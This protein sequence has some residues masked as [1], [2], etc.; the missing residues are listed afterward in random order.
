MAC[1]HPGNFLWGCCHCFSSGAKVSPVASQ[2]LASVVFV[3]CYQNVPQQSCKYRDGQ[4]FRCKFLPLWVCGMFTTFFDK[5]SQMPKTQSDVRRHTSSLLSFG[6][7]TT[8]RSFQAVV[9]QAPKLNLWVFSALHKI[10]SLH[11][12]YKHNYFSRPEGRKLCN[13]LFLR[14][15]LTAR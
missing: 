6:Y 9:D 4:K 7:F 12:I 5:F 8:S 11:Y 2:L 3:L 10:P 1:Q 15:P 14:V 13:S